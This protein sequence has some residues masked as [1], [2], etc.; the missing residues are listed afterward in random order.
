MRTKERGGE[1]KGATRTAAALTNPAY[2]HTRETAAP[3]AL[4]PVRFATPAP[5]LNLRPPPFFS[6]QAIKKFAKDAKSLL[7]CSVGL[8]ALIFFDDYASILIVGN[9]F[10]P[11]LGVLKVCTA[12]KKH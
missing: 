10:Q 7:T 11:L 1:S 6:N 2:R 8:G 9:S 3:S 5:S 12:N 4:T